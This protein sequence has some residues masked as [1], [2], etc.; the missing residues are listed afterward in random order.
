[1]IQ[2]YKEQELKL[3][4]VTN[5]STYKVNDREKHIQ[6]LEN[7]MKDQKASFNSEQTALQKTIEVLK[8]E[9][10][11]ERIAI[12]EKDQNHKEAISDLKH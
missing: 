1:M 11:S 6:Y 8:Q 3:S 10:S 4:D 12:R 7:V 5:Q 9:V 2:K